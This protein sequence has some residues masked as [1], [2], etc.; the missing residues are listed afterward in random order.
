P[1]ITIRGPLP[2]RGISV[3][4]DVSAA[5]AAR[6]PRPNNPIPRASDGA[7]ARSVRR[8]IIG[9]VLATFSYGQ[10]PDQPLFRQG[11]PRTRPHWPATVLTHHSDLAR[12]ST[13][14]QARRQIPSG[15]RPPSPAASGW[16]NQSFRGGSRATEVPRPAPPARSP[17]PP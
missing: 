16:R 1:Q 9:Q 2:V 17:P 14:R 15:R 11:Y 8:R 10:P 5:G 4:S 13:P 3:V 6:A 12:S 7:V